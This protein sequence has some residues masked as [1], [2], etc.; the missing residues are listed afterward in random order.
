MTIHGA[1]LINVHH[2]N[3]NSRGISSSFTGPLVGVALFVLVG[4]VAKGEGGGELS[5]K[6]SSPV[7]SIT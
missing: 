2:L 1:P 6:G 3:D 7:T 4:G 5:T